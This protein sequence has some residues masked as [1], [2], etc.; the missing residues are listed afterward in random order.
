MGQYVHC[1]LSNRKKILF[2]AYFMYTDKRFII[3]ITSFF[4]KLFRFLLVFNTYTIRN[5]FWMTHTFY[6]RRPGPSLCLVLDCCHTHIVKLYFVLLLS[7]PPPPPSVCDS[8]QFSLA[9]FFLQYNKRKL[10][11]YRENLCPNRCE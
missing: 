1:R 6:M 2:I 7:P 9:A 5:I 11:I 4:G 10:H 8:G 3:T